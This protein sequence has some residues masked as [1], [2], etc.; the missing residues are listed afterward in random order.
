[1][2][3]RINLDWHKCNEDFKKIFHYKKKGKNEK[4]FLIVG[5]YDRSFYECKKCKHVISYSNF[6]I[7]NLYNKQYLDQTYKDISGL[8]KRFNE[9][10]NLNIKK[11]DNKNRVKRINNFFGNKNLSVLD[12]GSGT[13]VFLNEMKINNH[14]VNGVDLDQRYVTFLKKK[15]IKIFCTPLN[16]LDIRKKFD[17]ITFN[18]VLE[19][20]NNPV[21]MI[22]DS[23]KFLKRDGVIYIEVPD[24]KAK[25]KGKHC[26]EFC[27][28][29]LQVFSK[30]SLNDMVN[31][32]GLQK[33]LIKDI[34]EPSNKYTIYGFMKLTKGYKVKI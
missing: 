3:N 32:A 4:N 11:S 26:G 6:K 16:K 9:I 18:K 30:I 29:H 23:L 24:K 2:K 7:S 10:S 19:H 34:I 31:A 15:K 33:I 14:Y 20:V 1:M 21:R 5:N 12:I 28:D 27:P 22:K 13:G 17:L 25:I 8:E